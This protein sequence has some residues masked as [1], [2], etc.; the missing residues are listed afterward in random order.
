MS[1]A[2]TEL[3]NDII[4]SLENKQLTLAV[5]V[6]LTKAFGTIDHILLAKLAHYVVRG[7]ALEW[8]RSYLANRRQYVQVND[9]RS[10][11]ETTTYGV[12]QGTV[13]GPLLVLI[14]IND[15]PRNFKTS[16]QFY[17]PITQ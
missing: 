11:I 17:L 9:S 14:Y 13:L 10:Q 1:N 4:T 6:D 12:P 8:F 15:L 2:I 5:F 3:S 16:N 7:I